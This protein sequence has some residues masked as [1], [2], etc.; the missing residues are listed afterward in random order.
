M[1]DLLVDT[2]Q[3]AMAVQIVMPFDTLLDHLLLDLVRHFCCPYVESV[4]VGQIR[5]GAEDH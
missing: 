1:A 2:W 5:T 4:E 3:L